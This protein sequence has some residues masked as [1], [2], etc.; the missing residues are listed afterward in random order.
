MTAEFAERTGYVKPNINANVIYGF[1]F[2]DL[3]S[4]PIILTA[5]N[6]HGGISDMWTNA[7]AYVGGAIDRYALG[8][9]LTVS[10]DVEPS[11][12]G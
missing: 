1:G 11:E 6:S 3:A 9:T 4:R 2:M 8:G 5:P 7:F 10:L 12:R